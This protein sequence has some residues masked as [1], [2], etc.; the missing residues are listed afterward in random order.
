MVSLADLK[1]TDYFERVQKKIRKSKTEIKIR[2]LVKKIQEFDA[3]ETGV[4]HAY[5]LINIL[6]YNLPAIFDEQTLIGL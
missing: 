1:S 4:I 5:K 2:D 6:K 3:G